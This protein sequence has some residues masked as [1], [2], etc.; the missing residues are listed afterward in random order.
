ME[1]KK[2]RP[3]KKLYCDWRSPIFA[4]LK[5]ACLAVWLY[6]YLRSGK[7]DSSYP[8]LYRIAKE[9]GYCETTVKTARGWLRK[10][11]WLITVSKRDSKGKYA[12]PVEQAAFPESSSNSPESKNTT[13]DTTVVVKHGG[14]KTRRRR[15]STVEKHDT[16]VDSGLEVDTE[17]GV[18][19]KNAEGGLARTP[20]EATAPADR[21]RP[22][23]WLPLPEMRRAVFEETGQKVFFPQQYHGGLKRL[24]GEYGGDELVNGVR[25]SCA[26]SFGPA[27]KWRQFAAW[28][29]N[30]GILETILTARRLRRER[31]P[32]DT[33]RAALSV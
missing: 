21:G 11:G 3:F 15:K 18:E 19:N 12:I 7:D 29:L 26:Q 8:S 33:E 1:T 4:E 14:G 20:S 22:Y 31:E 25:E 6:H 2:S 16:E 24:A 32:A 30:G 27:F 28:L 23:S 10:T 9:T 17:K 5:G 13:V